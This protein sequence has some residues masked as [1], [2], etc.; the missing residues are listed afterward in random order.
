MTEGKESR[1]EDVSPRARSHEEFRELCAL[2]P[3]GNLTEAERNELEAH[4]ATC[5]ACREIAKQYQE[6]VD[7]VIPKVAEELGGETPLDPNFSEEDASVSFRKRLSEE[8]ERERTIPGG[9]SWLSPLVVRRSRNFRRHFNHYHLGVPITVS[10]L[11]AAALGI[12]AFHTGES[13]GFDTARLEERK[14]PAA[15]VSSEASAVHASPPPSD[16]ELAARDAALVELRR[17]IAQKSEELRRLRAEQSE[18]QAAIEASAE[19]QKHLKQ[20]IAERDRLLFEVSAKEGSRREVE[21]KLRKLERDQSDFGVH[22]ARLETKSNELSAALAEERRVSA[23]QQQLLAKDRDIRELVGA[24]DLYITEVHD[25]VRTGET[26]KAFGRV[27][28][29]RGKSLVFYAY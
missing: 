22:T 15:T 16:E 3:S 10:A 11:L 1:D 27:F 26:Q 8:K 12:L 5:A 6:V 25:M 24:R 14:G 28:Y 20:V 4:L 17:E 2:A 29:T 9:E 21:D 7:Q 23:E 19:D 18:Q 13:V